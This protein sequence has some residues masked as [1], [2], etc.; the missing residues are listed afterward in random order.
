MG[1]GRCGEI[2]YLARVEDG[3]L[4]ARGL[5]VGKTTKVTLAHVELR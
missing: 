4:V 2:G 5:A 1:R 3:D